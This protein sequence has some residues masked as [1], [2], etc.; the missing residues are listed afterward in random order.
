MV[1]NGRNALNQIQRI[2]SY[3]MAPSAHY[4]GSSNQVTTPVYTPLPSEIYDPSQ[5]VASRPAPSSSFRFF[6]PINILTDDPIPTARQIQDAPQ[7]FAYEIAQVPGNG[8]GMSV[9][10]RKLSDPVA[11][12]APDTFPLNIDTG[13]QPRFLGRRLGLPDSTAPG[14]FDDAMFIY[15]L[16]DSSFQIVINVSSAAISDGANRNRIENA[17]P[18]QIRMSSIYNPPIYTLD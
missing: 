7:N 13:V 16:R 3:A 9:V 4:D 15:R 5:P 18:L 17:T 10:L 14:G 1:R 2:M 12:S 6:T 11:Y 8:E